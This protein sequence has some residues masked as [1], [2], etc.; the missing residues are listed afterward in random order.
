MKRISIYIVTLISI[1]A[2][3]SEDAGDCFQTAGKIIQQEFEVESF[4]NILIHERVGLIIEEGPTQKVVIE[5]GKNILSDVTVEVINKELIVKDNNACN[6]VREYNSTKVIVT[7]PN[8]KRI[9]NASEQDVVSKGTLTFPSIYLMSVGDKTKYLPVGDFHMH[10]NNEKVRVWSNGVAN[11]YI[12]GF[13][14]EL[15][16]SF[17]NGDTRFHGKDFIVKDI[18]VS[19]VSSNDMVIFPTESLTG[20][21]HSTGNVISYNKPPIVA[22]EELTDYGKLIFK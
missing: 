16:L 11:L 18:R 7:S 4:D 1:L 14:N 15:D 21:I 5:T 8:I 6:F 17:S 20:K 12:E 22:V 2:C 10:I 3:N 19:N 13:S 9:R